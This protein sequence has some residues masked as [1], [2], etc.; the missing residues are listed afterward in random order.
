MQPYSLPA[1]R[2]GILGVRERSVG[3]SGEVRGAFGSGLLG[4]RELWL[5][6]RLWSLG[7]RERSVGRSGGIGKFSTHNKTLPFKKKFYN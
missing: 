3:R 4:F 2:S 7:V 5:G 6:F 1:V